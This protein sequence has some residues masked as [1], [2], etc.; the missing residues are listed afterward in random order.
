MTFSASSA[1]EVIGRV[2]F[3]GEEAKLIR[4]DWLVEEMAKKVK[5]INGFYK[6]IQPTFLQKTKSKKTLS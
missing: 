5:S 4:P 6:I 1:P 2:L 3:F